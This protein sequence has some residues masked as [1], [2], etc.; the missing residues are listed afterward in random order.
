VTITSIEGKRAQPGENMTAKDKREYVRRPVD[1]PVDFIVQGRLYQGSI[2]NISEDGF[3]IETEGTFSVGQN[4]SMIYSF[5]LFGREN[6]AGR[7]IW[8]GSQV[9]GVKFEQPKNNK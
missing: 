5:H 8:I 2:R 7:I 6:R 4:I 9:I 3:L 1:I